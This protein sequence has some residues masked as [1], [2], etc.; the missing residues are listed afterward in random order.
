MDKN[1]LNSYIKAGEIAQAVKRYAREI[2][3]QDVPLIDIA[4]K[5]DDKIIE[6]GGE[7]GF[8]VNLS[9]DEVAA[10]FTPDSTSK[11]VATGLLKF[12][13]G[14]TVNGFFADT[15]ISFDL[16]EDNRYKNLIEIN[17]EMQEAVIKT[18]KPG[19][20]VSN[21]GEAVMV[22]LDEANKKHEN[23][24]TLIDG[25]SGHMVGK[26]MIHAGLTIPN[27]RNDNGT[28]LKDIA[29]AVEPFLTTGNGKIYSGEGGGIYSINSEAPIR[30]KESRKVVEYIKENFKTRPFCI[31]WLEREGFTKL[32]FIFASLKRQGIFYE[33]PKLIEKT[34]APVAQCENL[35]VISNGKVYCTT[36]E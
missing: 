28:E 13:V 3:K 31:R 21:I 7:L 11:E 22:V 25:L 2:I 16:T 35:F 17:K 1:E 14:I 26:N 24:F 15:A 32:K 9:I 12:D 6:L 34:K 8:P 20:N 36:Q 23:K 27:Y 18:V 30:D 4:R 10:H 29:F 5:I 33:Y 19:I